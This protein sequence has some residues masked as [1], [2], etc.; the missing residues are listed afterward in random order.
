[1]VDVMSAQGRS[2]INLANH[3]VFDFSPDWQPLVCQG[4][5]GTVFWDSASFAPD[6]HSEQ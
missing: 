5:R 4:A 3:A 2:Q 6:R 1:M